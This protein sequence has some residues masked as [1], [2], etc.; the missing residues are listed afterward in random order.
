MVDIIILFENRKSLTDYNIK[1]NIGVCY[2]V[3]LGFVKTNTK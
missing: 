3:N 1:E 2:E